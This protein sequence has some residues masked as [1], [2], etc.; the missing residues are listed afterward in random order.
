[1]FVKPDS[2]WSN[3]TETA[4]LTEA[5]G[6]EEDGFG[7]NVSISGD[8]VVAGVSQAVAGSN[9]FPRKGANIRETSGRLEGYDR[10]RHADRVRRRRI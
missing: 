10:K 1:M 9:P 2:G 5:N 8:T 4:Q 3:M 6:P 7:N